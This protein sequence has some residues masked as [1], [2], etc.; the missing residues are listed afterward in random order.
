MLAYGEKTG[1]NGVT[2]ERDIESQ[3]GGEERVGNEQ[4]RFSLIHVDILGKNVIPCITFR[5]LKTNQ[6]RCVRGEGELQFENDFQ[7]H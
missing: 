4:H 1:S 7:S 3:V 6:R 2:V 5:I